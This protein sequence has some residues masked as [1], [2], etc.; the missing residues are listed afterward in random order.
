[1]RTCAIQGRIDSAATASYKYLGSSIA[2]KEGS[3]EAYTNLGRYFMKYEKLDSAQTAFNNVLKETKNIFGA[4]AKYNMALIQYLKKD[5]KTSQ[6]TI[7]E[8]NDKFGAFEQ[9]VVKGFVLLADSYVAQKDYFQAKATLQSILEN[10]DGAD[11]INVC[12]IKLGE[13]EVLEKAQKTETKK[14]IEQRIKSSEK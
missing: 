6:K 3:I 13:I 1:M 9:W 11:I 4:E 10:Y 7:F 2:Q 8:L 12:K 14:Q 5:Y